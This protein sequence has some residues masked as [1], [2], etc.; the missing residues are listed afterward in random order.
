MLVRSKRA[1]AGIEVYMVRRSARSPFAPDAVVFP[2]GALDPEDADLA[3]AALRELAEET[4]VCL[5][6]DALV[7]FSHWITPPNEA[8]RYD[9]HFFIAA[10][11][12]DQTP[13]A[14]EHETHDGR[15][16]DPGD[17]LAK[18]RAGALHLIYPTVKHLERLASFSDVASLL[19]FARTKPI[20]TIAPY[21]SPDT[22]YV[23]PGDLEGAW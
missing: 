14:D 18:H 8:R 6:R 13:V 17:A 7:P 4:G 5:E 11:P 20:V 2:G 15:W 19:A 9:T 16:L 1:H 12:E 21:T 10:A 23:M 3:A 22:G